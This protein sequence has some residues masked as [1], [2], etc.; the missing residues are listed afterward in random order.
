MRQI[1]SLSS[2]KVCF[3]G[4]YLTTLRHINDDK[5]RPLHLSTLRTGTIRVQTVTEFTLNLVMSLF[6]VHL[7]CSSRQ[8]KSLNHENLQEALLQGL[9][10]DEL[11][12]LNT[13]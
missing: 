4:C 11:P 1:Q 10:T 2:A 7:R 3:W 13:S 6:V 12:Y 8:S 9:G 5:R